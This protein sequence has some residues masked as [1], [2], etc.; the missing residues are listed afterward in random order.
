MA[1]RFLGEADV[2]VEGKAYKLRFDF[3]TMCEFTDRTGK[4]ALEAFSA[5]QKGTLDIRDMRL[6]MQCCMLHHSPDATLQAAGE[7]LSHDFDAL[8]RVMQAAMPEAKELGAGADAGNPTPGTA[9]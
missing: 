3:N 2:T 6:L 4:D 5:A 7:L 8:L 9:A 1:N